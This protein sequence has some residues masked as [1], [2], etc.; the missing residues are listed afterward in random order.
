MGT[1][2]GVFT[3]VFVS[4]AC[5]HLGSLVRKQ[6]VD[7]LGDGQ[8]AFEDEGRNPASWGLAPAM[9]NGEEEDVDTDTG[10]G[11]DTGADTGC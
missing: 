2:V 6:L 8:I 7:E 4:G 5:P 1:G 9:K 11:V 3:G 10:A